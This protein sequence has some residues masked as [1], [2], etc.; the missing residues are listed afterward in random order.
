MPLHRGD[1]N[2]AQWQKLQPLLPTKARTGRPA[3]DHRKIL[4]GILWIHRT[5]AIARRFARSVWV[6]RYGTL[7]AS[8]VGA[9]LGIWQEILN[10]LQQTSDAAGQIDWEVHF[11]G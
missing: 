7:A 2:D 4:N 6:A 5:G 8:C 10:R 3:A 9:S 1:L 11:E